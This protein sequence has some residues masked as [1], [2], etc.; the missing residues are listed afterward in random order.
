MDHLVAY[1]RRL[2]RAGL[3]RLIAARPDA[4]IRPEPRSLTE[5]AQRLCTV[6]SVERALLPLDLAGLQ[7]AEALAALGGVA[8][9]VELAGFLDPSGPFESALLELTEQALVTE[10]GAGVLH[11]A[12]P[13]RG[14]AGPLRLGPRLAAVLPVLTAERVRS[15]LLALG[16]RA[17]TGRKS[18][19]LVRLTALLTDGEYVRQLVDSGPDGVRKLLVTTA[20]NGPHV[21]DEDPMLGYR[22]GPV[23]WAVER[24]LLILVGYG[25]LRMPAEIALALRGADYRAPF[26][27]AP[28]EPVTGVVDEADL[29]NVG[30]AAATE[31]LADVERVLNHCDRTPLATTKAGRVTVREL[32]R[33]TKATGLDEETVA[34][35]LSTTI[36][37]G[38]IDLDAGALVLTERADAWRAAEPAARLA[39]LLAGWWSA[40]VDTDLSAVRHHVVGYLAGLPV[41]ARVSDATALARFLGWRHPAAL[42]AGEG[43]E[44]VPTAW[45]EAERF[46]VVALGAATRLARAL[47]AGDA[48]TLAIASAGVAPAPVS[49]ATF[50]SDLSVV[51]SGVPAARLATLLDSAASREATGTASTWRFSAPSVRAGLDAGVDAEGLLADLAEVATGELPQ[52]LRYLVRDVAR[53]HGHVR[54]ASAA[55]VICADDQALLA[56][57]AAHRSLAGLRLRAVAPTVLVSAADPEKTLKALRDAGYEPIEETASGV[58]RV[59]RRKPRRVTAAEPVAGSTPMTVDAEAMADRLLSGSGVGRVPAGSDVSTELAAVVARQ[60]DNLSAAEH[61]VLVHAI[62]TGEPIRIDYVSGA[63]QITRRVIEK[64]ELT[65]NAVVAWCRLRDAERMFVLTRICSVAPAG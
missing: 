30:A 49:S 51:V 8:P 52:A 35:V 10:D 16:G 43:A 37:A 57:L 14:W 28:A 27:A 54:V 34:T 55:S 26:S 5:L 44:L 19:L 21:V 42:R 45:A 56:E 25:D 23:G 4:V 39:T 2:D 1:L 58:T 46:G 3:A 11:L 41:G 60:A 17:A 61:R 47:V 15:I 38:L 6:H 12:D 65:G 24:G 62:A 32:R 9:K 53:R 33:T 63:G 18:E 48:E 59:E 13:L 31:V 64:A 40:T 7:A 29:A 36:E 22:R 50:L 20:W